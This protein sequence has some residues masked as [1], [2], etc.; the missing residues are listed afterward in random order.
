MNSKRVGLIARTISFQDFQPICSWSTDVTH[1][2]TYRQKDG[3]TTCNCK[4]ALC[5]TVLHGKKVS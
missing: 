4:S 1:R 3:R 5:T 2:Q